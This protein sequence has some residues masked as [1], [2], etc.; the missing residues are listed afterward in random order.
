MPVATGSFEMMA[1]LVVVF[2]L[3]F[4]AILLGIFVSV[5]CAFIGSVASKNVPMMI[6]SGLLLAVA[7]YVLVF[8]ID[9]GFL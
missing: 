3:I 9:W 7:I 6:V 5:L 4:L 2:V 1:G 8:K